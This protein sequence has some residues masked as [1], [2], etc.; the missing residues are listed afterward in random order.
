MSKLAPVL[1]LIFLASCST[2]K[3]TARKIEKAKAVAIANPGAFAGICAVLF[4]VRDSLIKGDTVTRIDTVT[5]IELVPDTVL[6]G[7]T[8]VITKTLPGKTITRTITVTDTIIKE[9]TA[10]VEAIRLQLNEATDKGMELSR[11]ND[12]LKKFRDSM[13]GKVHIPW[14]VLV[15]IGLAVIG[16][17]YWRIKAGALNGVIS[18]MKGG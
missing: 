8:V 13:R 6:V 7:D 18:K 10:R 9:N 1:L 15:I 2:A 12:Q 11:E 3:R 5:N 4:P 17:A 16:W 14:W